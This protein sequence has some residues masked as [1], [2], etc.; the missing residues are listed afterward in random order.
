MLAAIRGYFAALAAGNLAFW[1]LGY[2]RAAAFGPPSDAAVGPIGFL[3]VAV[4]VFVASLATTILPFAA[5]LAIAVGL[6][7]RS[8]IYFA[9]C[10]AA[11]GVLTAALLIGTRGEVW[12]VNPTLWQHLTVSGALGGLVFWRVA[13]RRRPDPPTSR[14][15]RNAPTRPGARRNLSGMP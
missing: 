15:G 1:A 11:M 4:F 8:A 10:G 14:V 6:G 7:I 13:A 9:V 2:L 3:I 5:F 12:A